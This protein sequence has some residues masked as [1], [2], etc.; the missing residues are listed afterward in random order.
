M[1]RLFSGTILGLAIALMS[2]VWVC[3]ATVAEKTA[4]DSLAGF[5]Q[6]V[7]K[8]MAR[9]KVPGV[10]I[11]IVKDGEVAYAKGFGYRDLATM[12]PVTPDTLFFIGSCTKAFTCATIQVLVD[13]KKMDWDKPIKQYMPDFSLKDEWV[14]SHMT[15][16]DC[17]AHRTGYPKYDGIWYKQTIPRRDAVAQLADKDA[18]APFRTWLIYN[19]MMYVVAGCVM[20]AA[21]GRTWEENV[22][23]SILEPLGMSRTKVTLEDFLDDANRSKC[24]NVQVKPVIELMSTPTVTVAPAGG[25]YSNVTDMAKWITMNLQ[26]GKFGDK[27]IISSTGMTNIQTAQ[28][29]IGEIRSSDPNVAQMGYGL[30][31]VIESVRGHL[32][33]SHGGALDG[34]W[35]QVSLFPKDKVGWVI[36]VN[37]NAPNLTGTLTTDLEKRLVYPR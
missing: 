26:K 15:L 14:A 5:D 30:G 11:A 13:S 2:L 12:L 28:M 23:Q 21:T 10:A 33:V 34:F 7:E 29:T 36:F 3:G 35:T 19:N 20:E 1:R 16:V 8:V 9:E 18:E 22:K 25:V 17:V 32:K 4:L 31:W 24:Y 37:G 27:R 6:Y